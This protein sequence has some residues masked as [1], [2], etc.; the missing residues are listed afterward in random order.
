MYNC[1]WLKQDLAFS[2]HTASPRAELCCWF[3]KDLLGW[4]LSTWRQVT[5][6]HWRAGYTYEHWNTITKLFK[7]LTK[8][9]SIMFTRKC[10]MW[11]L[12]AW[13]NGVLYIRKVQIHTSPLAR[14][15]H[16]GAYNLTHCHTFTLPHTCC[17]HAHIRHGEHTLC[18]LLFSECDT[19][20]RPELLLGYYRSSNCKSRLSS[21][22][23]AREI[24]VSAPFL[25][26]WAKAALITANLRTRTILI[27]G[28]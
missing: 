14:T 27:S 7:L 13:I 15:R 21:V 10:I 25:P 11:K 19:F 20:L 2:P 18:S 1:F 16:C 28:Y 26:N 9:I 8:M 23:F 4:A 17:Y 24:L 5:S 3:W 12:Y 6:L 22:A